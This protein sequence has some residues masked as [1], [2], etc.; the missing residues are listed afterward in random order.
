MTDNKEIATKVQ[1]SVSQIFTDKVIKE[2][3]NSAGSIQVGD[4]QRNLIQGYFVGC[5]NALNAAENKRL[6]QEAK[7]FK[8]AKAQLPYIW[9]NTTIDSKLAQS[10]MVYAKLGLDMTIPNHLFP[11]PRKNNKTGKYEITFQEGYK[12]R[13]IIAKK[14]SLYPIKDIQC[15]LI[16]SNDKFVPHKKDSKHEHDTYELEISNPFS[17]GDL[18][19][20]FAYIEYEDPKQN[21]L[22]MMSKADIDKRRLKAQTDAFW[23]AWYEEMCLKTIISAACKKKIVIDP[24]KIDNEY[25]MYLAKDNDQEEATVRTTIEENANQVTIDVTPNHLAEPEPEQLAPSVSAPES[26]INVQKAEQEKPIAQSVEDKKQAEP[27]LGF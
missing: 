3:A 8:D 4:F 23:G 26:K 27:E 24:A 20:G 9:K 6:D 12:G 16:Y 1:P 18:V 19:G 25:R 11:I 7:G 14:Y 17:R 15:E 2:F 22:F 5:D 21:T 13:E 10:I